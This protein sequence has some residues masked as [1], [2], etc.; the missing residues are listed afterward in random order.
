MFLITDFYSMI[1]A[2]LFSL[3]FPGEGDIFILVLIF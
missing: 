3:N 2:V 1:P